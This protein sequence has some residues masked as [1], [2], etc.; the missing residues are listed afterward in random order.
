MNQLVI[1]IK[2]VWAL[3]IIHRDM[4]LANILLHFPNNPQLEAM[5]RQ[6]KKAFLA[7]VDLTKVNFQIKISDFGLS[8]ILDGTNTQ[9]SI[10]GTPLYSA[11]QL[12][13]KRGY[14]AKV[15]TWALGVIIYEMLMGVTPFHS[16]EMKDLIAKINDGRYNLALDEPITVECALFLTQ[17]LQMNENERIPVDELQQHP[18][19]SETFVKLPLTILDVERFSKEMAR[20]KRYS[21]SSA[22]YAPNAQ[23]PTNVTDSNTD[24]NQVILTTKACDQKAILVRQLVESE[25]FAKANVNI[26]ECSYFSKHYEKPDNQFVAADGTSRQDLVASITSMRD[27]HFSSSTA[28]LGEGNPNKEEAETEEEVLKETDIDE[29]MFI[30][31][32]RKTENLDF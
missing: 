28:D 7:E 8:T 22:S 5:N 10:C 6:Q 17:C 16:Y 23:V 21:I 25:N 27:N 18:F 24:D 30:F 14:S 19:I 32:D 31:P 11:P 13:K 2:D 4:K 29:D 15:D 20:Q 3:G 26:E 9:L 12:L 1:G